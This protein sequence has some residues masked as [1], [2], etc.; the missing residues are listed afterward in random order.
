[1]IGGTV[2]IE[3]LFGIPGLGHFLVD[4]LSRRSEY[5]SLQD[6]LCVFFFANKAPDVQAETGI[7][8]KI[9]LL[10]QFDTS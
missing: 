3:N 7:L 5:I 1:L 8:S 6:T 2:V 10:I 9:S 4:R